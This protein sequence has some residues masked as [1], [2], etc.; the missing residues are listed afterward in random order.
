MRWFGGEWTITAERSHPALGRF[1]RLEDELGGY[2]L[3]HVNGSD[4]AIEPLSPMGQP[5]A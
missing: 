2:D 4:G 5:V 1:F 3:V